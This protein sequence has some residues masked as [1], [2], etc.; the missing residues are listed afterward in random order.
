MPPTPTPPASE[1]LAYSRQLGL[2]LLVVA[3]LMLGG[4]GYYGYRAYAV[5]KAKAAEAKEAEADKKPPV[6][7]TKPTDPS[8]ASYV[9]NAFSL[10]LAGLAAAA[11]GLNRFARLPNLTVPTRTSSPRIENVIP[12][13]ESRWRASP[14]LPSCTDTVLRMSSPSTLVPLMTKIM[15]I[16]KSMDAFIGKD[17]EKGLDQLKA[18]VEA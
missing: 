3:I 12:A 16:F 6:E 10:G 17:F 9:Y 11:V 7:L 2:S 1:P 4:A 5:N 15:G 18:A 14:V 13:S 8:F